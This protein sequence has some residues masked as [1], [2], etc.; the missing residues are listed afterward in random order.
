MGMITRD[1]FPIDSIHDLGNSM[2]MCVWKRTIPFYEIHFNAPFC[3]LGIPADSGIVS[4]KH[5]MNKVFPVFLAQFFTE[6]FVF[7]IIG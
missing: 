7:F 6:L 3:H 2:I 4:F 1:A 5:L